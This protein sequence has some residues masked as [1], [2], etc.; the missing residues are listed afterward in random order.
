MEHYGN[1]AN[2]SPKP[3]NEAFAERSSVISLCPPLYPRSSKA[4][5]VLLSELPVGQA[6]SPTKRA[7]KEQ[8]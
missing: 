1:I 6:V 2:W 4:D 5:C 3:N 8:A 7:R